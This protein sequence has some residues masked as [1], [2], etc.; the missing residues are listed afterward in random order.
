MADEFMHPHTQWVLKQPV[1]KYV[2]DPHPVYFKHGRPTASSGAAAASG[3]P[4]GQSGDVSGQGTNTEADT[5]TQREASPDTFTPRIPP[6]AFGATVHQAKSQPN[7]TSVKSHRHDAEPSQA[8]DPSRMD[9]G[10][11]ESAMPALSGFSASQPMETP[12]GSEPYTPAGMHCCVAPWPTGMHILT[13]GARGMLLWLPQAAS[14]L[15]LLVFNP[16][17]RYASGVWVLAQVTENNDPT[18][19]VSCNCR[20]CLHWSRPIKYPHVVSAA[21]AGSA[22][23]Q[24]L[25]RQNSNAGGGG[26]KSSSRPLG[27]QR[28]SINYSL[29]AGNRKPD[30]KVPGSLHKAGKK[31]SHK[32]SPVPQSEVRKDQ[33]ALAVAA[34]IAEGKLCF[35]L[36]NAVHLL[37]L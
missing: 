31:S 24:L 1:A 35:H 28:N 6:S 20:H 7:F 9:Q 5:A 2:L 22:A 16:C 13:S 12:A 25:D 19:C 8:A 30:A 36:E 18:C 23:L 27:R 33:A 37:R 29:L 15:L 34:A 26:S 10:G 32:S 17:S 21:T 3:S 4:S 14:M 11:G